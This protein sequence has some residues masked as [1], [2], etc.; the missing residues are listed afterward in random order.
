MMNFI[1]GI[2]L[3]H[4]KFAGLPI[5]AQDTICAKVSSQL[6]YLRELPSEG[7]YGRPYGQGWLCPP[8]GIDTNTTGTQIVVGPHKTYEEFCSAINRARQVSRAVSSRGMEWHP[9]ELEFMD[10]FTSIF[11]DWEPH[12]PKF[13]W[14]DPKISNVVARQIKG[15]DGSEDWEVFLIDWEYCGWY[16]AWLQAMQVRS[17]SGIMLVDRTQPKEPIVHRH[18]HSEI[19]PMILKDFA[20]EPDE[21]KRA[22]IRENDWKF[23]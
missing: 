17:R 6:R 11:P 19:I 3:D 9:K 4:D 13:T 5:H 20:P 15:E 16:P 1:E 14:I 21:Q 8:P 10:K 7:Y 23:Y 12:E 2:L 22:V 18:R